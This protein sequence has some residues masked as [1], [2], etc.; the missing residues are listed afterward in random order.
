MC[1]LALIWFLQPIMIQRWIQ[2]FFSSDPIF[3]TWFSIM[4]GLM[5]IELSHYSRTDYNGIYHKADIIMCPLSPKN[6]HQESHTLVIFIIMLTENVSQGRQCSWSY[7]SVWL[8]RASPPSLSLYVTPKNLIFIWRWNTP[9]WKILQKHF[10]G[11]LHRWCE[12]YAISAEQPAGRFAGLLKALYCIKK[13]DITGIKIKCVTSEW[14]T[15][16]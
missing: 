2:I 9:V 15:W 13:I 12:L 16:F 3:I 1:L 5:R 10:W 14:T 8:W 6:L 4:Q 7:M 11:C